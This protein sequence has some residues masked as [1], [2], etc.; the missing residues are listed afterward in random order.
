MQLSVDPTGS[1]CVWCWR[2]TNLCIIISL[3]TP[4]YE[5]TDFVVVG[6]K[7]QVFCSSNLP[8]LQVSV[9]SLDINHIKRCEFLNLNVCSIKFAIIWDRH[10]VRGIYF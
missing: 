5:E 2:A 8:T 9:S 10:R 1:G 6:G 4:L 3:S 7:A